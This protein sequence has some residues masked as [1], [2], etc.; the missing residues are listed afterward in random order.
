MTMT[1]T[2]AALIAAIR[3]EPD[4]DNVR[5][6]YADWLEENGQAERAEFI[7]LEC[8]VAEFLKVSRHW[9]DCKCGGG[10]GHHCKP[11]D[12]KDTWSEYHDRRWDCWAKLRMEFGIPEYSAGDGRGRDTKC[13]MYASIN[14]LGL[15]I[16]F[17]ERRGFIESV[18]CPLDWWLSHG[19]ELCRWHPVQ[20]VEI[21]ER[22]LLVS[23]LSGIEDTFMIRRRDFPGDVVDQLHSYDGAVRLKHN[24]EMLYCTFP[25]LE[26][27]E[28]AL[29]R[30]LI[31]WA[32]E[33]FD[34][35]NFLATSAAVSASSGA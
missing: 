16:K 12:D 34:Q 21:A 14:R 5:L 11:C 29:S 4:D 20:R 33:K 22:E 17:T 19:P 2:Q 28:D 24:Q 18:T 10:N 8:Q 23:G 30:A 31:A 25:T 26:A 6:V 1:D 35:P 7:R 27:A 3:A 13:C 9:E 32:L 15:A